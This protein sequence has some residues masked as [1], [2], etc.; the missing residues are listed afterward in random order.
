VRRASFVAALFLGQLCLA[1]DCVDGVTPDCSDPAN[2]CGPD[3][4]ARD[5]ASTD[6][7]VTDTSPPIDTGAANDAASDTSSDPDADSGDQ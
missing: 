3:V 4:S 6:A 2:Q 5:G 7:P 1:G